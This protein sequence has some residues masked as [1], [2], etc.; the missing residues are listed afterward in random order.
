MSN[1]SNPET[2]PV[3]QD[4]VVARCLATP[5]ASWSP[6]L[7][8]IFVHRLEDALYAP[9]KGELVAV[10]EQLDA[11]LRHVL[12]S[13]PDAM[14]AAVLREEGDP[15]IRAA[16]L[17]GNLSFAHQFAATVAGKRPDDEFFTAFADAQVKKV[18]TCLVGGPRTADELAAETALALAEVR[19]KM[20]A[21]TGLGIVDF[22]KRFGP[23]A[24]TGIAEYFLTPAAKQYTENPH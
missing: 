13:A 14:R 11:L 4:A 16:F 5:T 10:G 23:G 24:E 7:M 3:G 20:R 22:R 2:Q 19:A 21:L 17:L 18:V 9:R 6:N 12:A 1:T 8:A 15:A